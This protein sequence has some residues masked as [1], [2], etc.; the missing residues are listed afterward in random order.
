MH[1]NCSCRS[2]YEVRSASILCTVYTKAGYMD[3]VHKRLDFDISFC[4]A[5]GVVVI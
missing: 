2:Q 3:S 5:I 4:F 1:T